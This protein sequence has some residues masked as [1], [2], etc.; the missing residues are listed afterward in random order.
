[1]LIRDAEPG[2]I[3]ALALLW[4]AAWRDAHLAL[5]PPELA[6]LRTL[7]SF[8][9]RIAA[10]LADI[11]VL[12][13]EGAPMGFSWLK[14]DELYQLFVAADAR[15]TGVAAALIADAESGLAARG[16]RTAWLACMIGNARAARF[17]EKCGWRLAGAV[18]D[19]VETSAGRFPLEVWRYEKRLLD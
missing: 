17:Y 5:A 15:G 11:R 2:D 4:R 14:E 1:M 13:P 10:G 12:G 16:V 8:R 3:D 18:I 19:E 7:E 9:A 6:R